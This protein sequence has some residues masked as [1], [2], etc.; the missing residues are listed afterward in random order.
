SDHGSDARLQCLLAVDRAIATVGQAGR[1]RDGPIGADVDPR[2]ASAHAAKDRPEDATDP[3]LV[4]SP[5]AAARGIGYLGIV[6]NRD[7]H[8][9]DVADAMGA[10]VLE[11]APGL[12]GEQRV[13]LVGGDNHFG[14]WHVNR[15]V[16]RLSGGV[17]D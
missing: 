13:G 5:T 16:T 3:G 14:H 10:L 8:G 11:E 12:I 2:Y 4:L 9:E 1:R 17:V 15:L 7:E 6:I